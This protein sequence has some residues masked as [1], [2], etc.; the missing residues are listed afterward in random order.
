MLQLNND[1]NE[2]YQKQISQL[3]HK[4]NPLIAKNQHKYLLQMKPN[5][6]E[7]N[8]IIKT[9]KIDNP[10]RPVINSIKAPSYKL[11]RYFNKLRNNLIALPYSADLALELIKLHIAEHHRLVTF[12][13]KDLYVN[14]PIQDIINSTKFW[15]KKTV[16]NKRQSTRSANS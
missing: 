10:I 1:P 15:L 14:L 8:A 3:L 7:L 5:A 9:H 2:Q 6:P 4:C 11:A 13:I 12:D 16:I